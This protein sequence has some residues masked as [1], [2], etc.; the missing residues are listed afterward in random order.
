MD[1]VPLP[2][3][4][5]EPDAPQGERYGHS[6]RICVVCGLPVF[7]S[8]VSQAQAASIRQ[9]T[10]TTRHEKA[11]QE[12]GSEKNRKQDKHQEPEEQERKEEHRSNG[13]STKHCTKKVN[14]NSRRYNRNN[15]RTISKCRSLSPT[16]PA[17]PLQQQHHHRHHPPPPPPQQPRR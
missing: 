8:C 1:M 4:G 13:G 11:Q 15:N 7:S 9:T 12:Q 10:T 5:S 6:G 3:D 16:T 2:L 17:T 14:I